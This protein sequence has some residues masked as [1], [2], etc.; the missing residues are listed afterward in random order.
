MHVSMKERSRLHSDVVVAVTS[1]DGAMI[2][3][4]IWRSESVYYTTAS[5]RPLYSNPGADTRVRH[6]PDVQKPPDPLNDK[7]KN[8]GRKPSNSRLLILQFI[9]LIIACKLY[10]I[11]TAIAGLNQRQIFSQTCLMVQ[12]H[13]IRQMYPFLVYCQQQQQQRHRHFYRRTTTT[14]L[15][16]LQ[17]KPI[18]GA[19]KPA[20]YELRTKA[21]SARGVCACCKCDMIHARAPLS[22]LILRPTPKIIQLDFILII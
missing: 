17:F 16:A 15:L 6:A 9:L 4:I 22:L 3:R 10:H 14:P 5:A 1:I 18:N 11:A 20:A 12:T 13:A 8:G 2:R 19:T 21:S 7:S